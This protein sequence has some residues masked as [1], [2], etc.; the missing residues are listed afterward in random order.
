[1]REHTMLKKVLIAN[2]GEIAIR[3]IRA[4]NELG[5]KTVAIYTKADQYA[6]HVKRASE[7][8]CIG[9]EPVEPYLNIP[10][11]I[12]IAKASKCD[13]IHPGYG[14]LSENANFARACDKA[15]ITFIGPSADVIEKMGSKIQA[16][17]AMIDAG[18]PVIPGSDGELQSLQE[19][20]LNFVGGCCGSTPE[21][22]AAIKQAVGI[23]KPRS[24]QLVTPSCR[25]SG[26]EP[27]NIDG[28]S[29]FVNVGER[30]N[31]SGSAKFLRL[32]KNQQFEEALEV[33]RDQVENGAQIIDVNMDEAML[34]SEQAMTT[35]L[36]LIASMPEISRIPIMIDSS[37]WS[38]IEAGLKCIQGKG[39]IN[40][41]SLKEGEVEFIRQATLAKRYGAA[42]VIM[43]FD[44]QGQADSLARRLKIVD[45][46][47]KI[48]VDELHFED[49][50]LIFDLNIFAVATGIP[51]HDSYAFDFIEATRKVRQKYPRVLLSG[52]LL[53]SKHEKKVSNQYSRLIL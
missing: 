17:K 24:A 14:F 3:A 28:N 25:L 40:S 23:A 1:M 44:E 15:G 10:R 9:N 18:I 51:E 36:N 11:I 5:I 19:G 26:L 31:V 4:C 53:N 22:I 35:F 16:R 20:L 29:L 47:Y 45:R 38:V 42:V 13:G 21:H 34:D 6:L 52:G 8:Y 50:D 49:E 48:L 2:R 43:A 41:I 33:A 7:A 12:D 39:I 27:L 46:C 30:T 37:K 32:I